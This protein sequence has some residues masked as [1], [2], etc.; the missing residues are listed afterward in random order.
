MQLS[1]GPQILV[2]CDMNFTV[3][4]TYIFYLINK[5]LHSTHNMKIA[6]RSHVSLALDATHLSVWCHITY[7]LIVNHKNLI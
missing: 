2:K 4:D 6:F 1:S 3:L 5:L 7:K